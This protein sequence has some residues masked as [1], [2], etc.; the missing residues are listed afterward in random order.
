MH[1]VVIVGGSFAGLAVA[2]RLRG[3]RVLLIDQHPIGSHQMST[4]GIPHRLATLLG[5][6]DA[7]MET[8]DA[9]IIHVNGRRFRFEL[10]EPYATFNY[11]R[12]CE[13]MLEQTDAEVV[14]ARATARDGATVITTSGE[15]IGRFLVI[16][17]GWRAFGSTLAGEPGNIPLAARG[18][19]TELPLRLDIEPGLHFYFERHIIESGY[20]WVFPCGNHTRIGLGSAGDVDALRRRLDRF[21]HEFGLEVGP[22]HGGVMPFVRR[23]PVVDG[24]FLVGDAAGQCLPTTAEG[25][26]VA[27]RHGLACGQQLAMALRGEIDD[28]TARRRYRDLVARTDRSH[29]RLT[30]LMRLV[31]R[32]PEPALE[33]VARVTQ[34]K[35][36]SD[37]LIRRY[38]TDTGWPTPRSLRSSSAAC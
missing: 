21:V 38:L 18:L 20:A 15:F 30:R 13:L 36:V 14:T 4:C 8:H 22:T 34:P 17:T 5:A 7:I 33:L 6:E 26:R 23:E 27:V 10:P 16:A 19:E 9:A 3:H 37:W 1:D 25:I 2:M 28:E 32:A 11:R 24:A 29:H 31:D 12:F 35:P